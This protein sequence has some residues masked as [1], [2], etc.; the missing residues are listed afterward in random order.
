MDESDWELY[1]LYA[2][3]QAR[4]RLSSIRSYRLKWL[5]ESTIPAKKP[6]FLWRCRST[7]TDDLFD[8][9]SRCKSTPVV[10]SHV[11]LSASRLKLAS[12]RTPRLCFACPRKHLCL[13]KAF[14]IDTLLDL[15]CSIFPVRSFL[16]D[17][18]CSI[19]PVR[20]FLFS[21]S[22]SIF[23]VQFLAVSS[24]VP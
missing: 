13:Q 2:Y 12:L 4:S 7:G 23:P 9:L 3:G 5:V 19:F 8:V 22:C 15:S 21:L 10:G 14:F 11:T 16:F 24:C 17:L 20:S 18:S 1:P 6:F